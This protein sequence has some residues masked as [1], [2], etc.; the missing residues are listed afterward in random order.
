MSESYFLESKATGTWEYEIQEGKIKVNHPIKLGF[1]EIPES[2]RKTLEDDPGYQA[3]IKKGTYKEMKSKGKLAAENAIKGKDTKEIEAAK[4]VK[5]A[6]ELYKGKIVEMKKDFDDKT[7]TEKTATNEKLQNMVDLRGEALRE[8]KTL[9]EENVKILGESSSLKKELSELKA[10][11][12]NK[13]KDL[14]NQV[15][16]LKKA[17]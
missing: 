6:K 14:E 7:K 10:S 17:K 2:H 13:I 12:E 16:N 3:R 11:S 15:K 4:D 1:N 8:V 5:E 9:K